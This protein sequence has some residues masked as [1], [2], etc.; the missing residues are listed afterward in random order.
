MTSAA[1]DI[2]ILSIT[3][4][5]IVLAYFAG[6]LVDAVCGGGGLLTVP[7]LISAG[8]PAHMVVGTNQCVIVPGCLTSVYKYSKS[9]N[10]DVKMALWTIPFSLIG[11]FIGARLNIVLS[12][13]YLQIIMMILLPVLAV[14]SLIKTNIGEKD[15]SDT[16]SKK[17]K[18]TGAI[19]IGLFIS[20]YHAFYGPAS[21]LFYVMAFVIFLKYDI[22]K[23]NGISRLVLAC[24]SVISSIT[25]ISSGFVCWSVIIPA[26]LAYIV[27][28]YIGAGIAIKKGAKFVKPVYYCVLGMLFVKLIADLFF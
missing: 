12:E 4:L 13:K 18:L 27:G 20:A 5:L 7:V 10:I 3:G 19:L 28:N 16:V 15:L 14:V 6:G 2:S 24:V 9:K 11:A 1:F 21:G 17:K 26:A 22:I 23:A 25:Y 8:M